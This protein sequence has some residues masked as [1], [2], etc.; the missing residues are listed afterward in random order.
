MIPMTVCIK[1]ILYIKK[2][3]FESTD[4]KVLQK[5]EEDF[6]FDEAVLSKDNKKIKFFDLASENDWKKLLSS[7]FEEK[8]RNIFSSSMKD[9]DYIK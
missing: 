7:E 5:K 4:F 6:G 8:I 3:P 1:N 9:L 2:E